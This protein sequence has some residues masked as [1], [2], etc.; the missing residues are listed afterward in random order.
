MSDTTR[1]ALVTGAA[2]GLGKGI[3]VDL[4]AAGYALA[5]TYRPDG[6]SPAQTI[7]A[8]RAAGGDPV[9]IAADAAREEA[10]T[11]T[12]GAVLER[13]GRLDIVVHAVGPFIVRR[14]ERS[15]LTDYRTMLDGNLT[16]AVVLALAALP[17]MRE[18][19]FGRLVFF[20][21]NGSHATWPGAGTSLYG[22]AKAGLVAFARTLALEEAARGITVNVIEPGEIRDKN[23][24]RS[25]AREI[26]A[27]NPTGHAGSWE[28]V[29]GAVRFLVS[30]AA[31]FINGVT[32]GVNGGLAE[33]YE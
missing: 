1:V 16:S 19:G 23:V 2:A 30:D 27:G 31:G 33:P 13:F 12:V 20:G 17:G 26:T 8:I 11:Q 4:S 29:A 32:L 5:F 14:F 7:A 25:A 24:S 10:G 15:S 3:A 21:M 28:D 6:T 9:A 18:R 22:A